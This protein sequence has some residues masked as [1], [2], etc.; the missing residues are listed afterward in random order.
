MSEFHIFF[1]YWICDGSRGT[2][3]NFILTFEHKESWC[4]VLYIWNQKC[5]KLKQNYFFPK[6]RK[7]EISINKDSHI[8]EKWCL[9]F[10]VC[11][12]PLNNGWAALLRPQ[13]SN[14]I[15]TA[16]PAAQT[17]WR[18]TNFGIEDFK[19]LSHWW[20]GLRWLN[21]VYKCVS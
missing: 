14:Y 17:I 2:H 3:P 1:K 7:N 10:C 21:C 19:K 9:N 4:K 12:E 8:S 6:W 11:V 20:E 13:R 18:Q 5:V 15:N 16:L